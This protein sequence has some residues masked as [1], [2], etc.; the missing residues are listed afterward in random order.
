MVRSLF[1]VLKN[2]QIPFVACRPDGRILACN[3]AFSL[4]TGY[5]MEELK[6]LNI[7][8]D[9]TPKDLQEMDS[10]I[11]EKFFNTG[12][13]ISFEKEYVRRDG[14]RVSVELFLQLAYD[15]AGN[16]LFYY[17][18]ITDL[19]ERKRAENGFR[20]TQKFLNNLFNYANAPII[21]WDHDFIITRF[22]HA[23][24]RLTGH[25]S[26]EVIGKELSILFPSSSRE[27]SLDMIRRTL[28]GEH[29]DS[30]EIPIL[31]RDG[32]VRI[33]LWNSANIYDE[34]NKTLLAT[35]AQGQDITGRKQVEEELRETRDYL[36]KMFNYANAPIIVWDHDFIITRFNHG[37]E[38][39]TGYHSCEVIGKELSV[40]FPDNCRDECLDNIERT[41]S[42]EHWDSVE[43]PIRCKNGDIR[44]ALW[45][46]AN[47]HKD[48]GVSI[49]AT[50][51]Q[52]QDI[53]E[54]KTAEIALRDSE[55]KFKKLIED[56]QVGVMLLDG[57][58][59][60]LVSNQAARSMIGVRFKDKK[61]R[62]IL[63]PTWTKWKYIQEDGSPL[64]PE[65]NPIPKCY[66]TRKPVKDIVIGLSYPDTDKIVWVL[67]N[68]EPFLSQDG[69]IRQ[70]IC[71]LSNV[72]ERR[73]V[74][75]A[76]KEAKMQAELYLDLMGHDIN[77]LNQI[78]IGYL[79]LA[80]M[81]LDIQENDR[82]MIS[83]PL[84]VLKSS[85]NLI[86]NVRKLQQAKTCKI[87]M[88]PLDIGKILCE[89]REQYS[90]IPGKDI[91]INYIN[92]NGCYV[93]ANE[94][95]NDVFLNILGNAIKHTNDKV[96]ID[97]VLSEVINGG[98]KYYR[99]SIADNGPGIPDGQKEL[100]FNRLYRGST[101]A[102]GKGLGLFLVKTLVEKFD[103]LVWV[104]DKMPGDHNGG[105]KFVVM[106]P[107]Y[108]P[109]AK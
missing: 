54:R 11:F 58:G 2:S 15:D 28:S 27:D 64:S 94:L 106:L 43:I 3:I 99:V 45:N 57:S 85:S 40:L 25:L 90:K 66:E 65:N 39:L 49:M 12:I 105:S 4:L 87:R 16:I 23:F 48:D 26:C 81:S 72:T 59:N 70:V 35:I 7:K 79:E 19:T 44:I 96:V 80:N 47:I 67:M 50:I 75:E 92:V 46:S 24:E 101:K 5:T 36:D 63:D 108:E 73:K 9:L 37:F 56:L 41:L 6:Y 52:G 69:S 8:R 95:L 21:V 107:A 88:E 102:K 82:M 68:V 32:E 71:T 55:E 83:K 76:L 31:C 14:S 30:V 109:T 33:V 53:T 78:G 60:I 91:D 13:P 77:N 29:W 89:V 42:G 86:S 104:E 20:E 100:I 98:Q 1:K 84:E 10:R 103:G 61:I 97:V 22:N 74:D 34:D 51:A 18:F 93:M 62:N 38:R 17:S